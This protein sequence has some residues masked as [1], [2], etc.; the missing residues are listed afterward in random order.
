MY[1]FLNFTVFEGEDKA[2]LFSEPHAKLC[3]LE[4]PKRNN[5]NPQNSFLAKTQLWMVGRSVTVVSFSEATPFKDN[6]STILSPI[7]AEA[8]TCIVCSMRDKR[9][10]HNSNSCSYHVSYCSFLTAESKLKIMISFNNYNS[11]L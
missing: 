7:V 5:K 3:L 1:T 4:L 10:R 6:I 2:S 11:K 8:S 9:H